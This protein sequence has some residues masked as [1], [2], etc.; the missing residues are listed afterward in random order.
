[1]VGVVSTK[2]SRYKI[3]RFVKTAKGDTLENFTLHGKS[4]IGH[5]SPTWVTCVLTSTKY[6]LNS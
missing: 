1:M 3:S 5:K 2:I 6:Q 4:Y